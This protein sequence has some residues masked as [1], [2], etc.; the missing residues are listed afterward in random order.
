MSDAVAPPKLRKPRVPRYPSALQVDMTPLP[1]TETSPRKS[2]EDIDSYVQSAITA[3]QEMNVNGSSSKDDVKQTN[4]LEKEPD[5]GKRD[6]RLGIL[7][8]DH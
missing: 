8:I 7:L 6:P 3:A 5:R 1:N 4:L 2:K